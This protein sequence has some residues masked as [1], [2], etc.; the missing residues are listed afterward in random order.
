MYRELLHLMESSAHPWGEYFRMLL[1][2]KAMV[3]TAPLASLWLILS[4]WRSHGMRRVSLCN[5]PR[6]QRCYHWELWEAN[7]RT[8]GASIKVWRFFRWRRRTR[9]AL[10]D[11]T[12]YGILLPWQPNSVRSSDFSWLRLTATQDEGNIYWF[13]GLYWRRGDHPE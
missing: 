4:L 11:W 8:Q 5:P 2:V 9:T 3:S 6:S 1:L 13:L 12:F 7:S 10:R